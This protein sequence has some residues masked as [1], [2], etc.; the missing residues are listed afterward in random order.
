LWHF[1]FDSTTDFPWD[2]IIGAS[3][4][5]FSGGFFFFDAEEVVGD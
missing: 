4:A 2:S 3:L 1:P 5:A